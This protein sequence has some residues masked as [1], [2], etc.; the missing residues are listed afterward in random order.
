MASY[1]SYSHTEESCFFK[2]VGRAN[3]LL[4]YQRP[5]LEAAPLSLSMLH[6]GKEKGDPCPENSGLVENLTSFEEQEPRMSIHNKFY[7][8]FILIYM[9]MHACI[10][11]Y[12]R[13]CRGPQRSD[14]GV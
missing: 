1:V 5:S 4:Q 14:E 11:L 12:A 7:F 8:L 3:Q 13:A 2:K 9:H 6:N 10:Y